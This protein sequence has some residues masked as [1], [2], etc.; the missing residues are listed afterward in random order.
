MRSIFVILLAVCGLILSL[1]PVVMDTAFAS[2]NQG[3]PFSCNAAGLACEDQSGTDVGEVINN[4][5][6]RMLAN[7]IL[8]VVDIIKFLVAAIAIAWLAWSSLLLVTSNG[9]EDKVSTG[10]MGV[11]WSLIGLV[12]MLVVDT[13]IFDILYGGGA[14]VVSGVLASPDNL[15][16]ASGR[17]IIEILAL[18]EWVKGILIIVAVVYVMVSGYK[19]IVA[20][21]ETEEISQQKT[22]FQ[23]V[24]VGLLVILVNDV[25]IRE[26]IY[27]NLLGNDWRVTY[28]PDADT[29]VREAIAIIQYFLQF[30]AVVA[31]V[32]FLYGGS[33][34]IISFGDQDRVESGKKVI[35]GA[36]IGIV[37]VLISYVVTSTFASGVVQ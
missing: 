1:T 6:Q 18:L 2:Q 19:M 13:V 8:S 36:I 9:E 28:N 23:W 4:P 14:V 35:T 22:V 25:L 34:W 16:T 31:F 24:G 17:A 10:K 15:T 30:L 12:G 7:A 33:Q 3:I 26:V 5:G 21:G 27:P 20:L 29:G 37:V 11:A 32:A